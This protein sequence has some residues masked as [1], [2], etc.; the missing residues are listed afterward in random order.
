LTTPVRLVVVDDHAVVRD[1]LRALL[2]TRPDIEVVGVAADGVEA[3]DVIGRTGPD[4]VLMDLAMPR[5]DGVEATRRVLARPNPPLVPEL[6]DRERQVLDLV[7]AGWGNQAIGRRL[8]ISPKTVANVVSAL[9]VK[10]GVPDR[11]GAAERARGAG[12]GGPGR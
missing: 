12:L 9:L 11:A 4:V 7:A 2:S 3:V 5:M 8:M 1:G 10:L 6:S